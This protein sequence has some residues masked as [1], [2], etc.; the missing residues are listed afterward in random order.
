MTAKKLPEVPVKDPET[1]E[2]LVPWG[3]MH[4]ELIALGLINA[5]DEE[6]NDD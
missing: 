1:D 6:I 2:I 4:D 5:T 3:T